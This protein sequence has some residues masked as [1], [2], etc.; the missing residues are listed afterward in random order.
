MDKIFESF[1]RVRTFEP[2]ESKVA[3]GEVYFVL[4]FDDE[5]RAYLTTTDKHGNS[6]RADYRH[7]S[8]NTFLLLRSLA[9]IHDADAV[10]VSWGGQQ[11]RIYLDSHPQLIYQILR[12]E[13]VVNPGRS[14]LGELAGLYQFR[15]DIDEKGRTC[16]PVFRLE[17]V[18]GDG[19]YDIRDFR[20][21]TDNYALCDN[22]IVQVRPIG[23][24]FLKL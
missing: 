2:M 23:E 6:I 11:D 5:G 8:G 17:R 18:E 4:G 16:T 19:P 20:F 7:Y 12:C 10:T 22:N 15:A 21:I 1:R 13:N 9:A 14:P 3:K 24:E